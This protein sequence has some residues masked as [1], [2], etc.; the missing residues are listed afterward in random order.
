MTDVAAW[1]KELGLE[2]YEPAFRESEITIAVLPEL[3]EADL[4]E[5]GLPLGPRKLLLRAI[6]SLTPGSGAAPTPESTTPSRA[7][8]RRQLTLLFCDLVGSTEL[9]AQLD[10]EDFGQV[11]RAY[12][13]ACASVVERWG[14][15]VA[16]YMGDGVLAYFGWPMAHEDEAERAVRAGLELIESVA[17]L[18]TPGG[19]NLTVRVGIATGQ[20]VVGDLIGTGAAQ[21][22]TVVGDTPNLAA[23]LQTLARP[24]TVVIGPATQRL[25]GGAFELDDLGPQLLKGLADPVRAWRVIGRQSVESRFEARTTGLT[26]LVGREQEVALLHDRWRRASNGGGQTVLLSGEPGIGKSRIVRT[27]C[28]RVE[29]EP[30]LRL[31]CQCSP[32]HTSTAFHPFVEQLERAAGFTRDDTAAAKLDKLEALL[33]QGT[34]RVGE[35]APLLAAMLSIPTVGRYPPLAHGPERQ[36]ELTVA[37]LVEQLLGLA[38][39]RP[40]LCVCEDVHWADPAPSTSSTRP[41]TGSA[42]RGCCCC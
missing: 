23:R 39:Q 35:V 19:G 16:K 31:R 15:H 13:G 8:E 4:K 12:H 22:E 29:A 30:H 7:A 27:I 2:R 33:A 25:I 37:A 40:V 24:D 3:T 34:E 18:E 38:R 20:V 28:E 26:P 5:L 21:E 17:G 10:L 11:I 32:Y 1:L 41:S 36:R 14:G 9:S 42:A 6:A